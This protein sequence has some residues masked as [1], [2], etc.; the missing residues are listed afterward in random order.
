MKLIYFILFLLIPFSGQAGNDEYR[1]NML[2]AKAMIDTATMEQTL[3]VAANYFER[4]AAMNPGE[5]LP[6]YYA[7]YCYA[8]VSHLHE[9]TG[10]RDTWV[11]KAQL[12]IDKAFSSVPENPEVLVMKGF[13]L[14]ARMDINP[15]A[16]GL[17]YYAET[18]ACFDRAIKLC[19]ENPRGYLWKGINLFNTPAMFGGGRDKGC[20]LI[21]IAI[22]KFKAFNPRDS[23]MPD[24]GYEYALEMIE[25]CK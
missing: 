4:I 1:R 5:W 24:W 13:V 22:E 15:M 7:A 3:I 17:K 23:L 20:K 9:A 11:D 25:K 8:R 21:K 12:Q 16:R 18:M 10:K 19:P 14:Q 6:C 2:R